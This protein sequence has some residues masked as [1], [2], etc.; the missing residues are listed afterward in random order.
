[1]KT[2]YSVLKGY[3]GSLIYYHRWKF[4]LS[5]NKIVLNSFLINLIEIKSTKKQ[6]LLLEQINDKLISL[7]GDKCIKLMWKIQRQLRPV[8]YQI[9]TKT[10]GWRLLLEVERLKLITMYSVCSNTFEPNL[11]TQ[12]WMIFK[13]D[14]WLEALILILIVT[15]NLGESSLIKF[16]RLLKLLKKQHETT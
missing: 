9:C 6:V 12:T 3:K 15:I 13:F 4:Q 10:T 7:K 2:I 5:D 11:Q 16:K 14:T 1:M 8:S